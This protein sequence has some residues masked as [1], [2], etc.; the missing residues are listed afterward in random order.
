MHAS[1]AEVLDLHAQVP[2]LTPDSDGLTPLL[3]L[4]LLVL[5]LRDGVHSIQ[6]REQTLRWV[7]R[8]LVQ[9]GSGIQG[10]AVGSCNCFLRRELFGER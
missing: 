1:S 9:L 5:D 3:G 10:L 4:R 8:L 6:C 2:D 7:L